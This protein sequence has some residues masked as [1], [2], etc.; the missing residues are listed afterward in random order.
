MEELVTGVEAK[1]ESVSIISDRSRLKFVDSAALVGMIAFEF[2]GIVIH[3]SP[4]H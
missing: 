4:W 2:I 1:S 3:R